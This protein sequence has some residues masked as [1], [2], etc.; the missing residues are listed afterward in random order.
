M[1]VIMCGNDYQQRRDDKVNPYGVSQ[2]FHKQ[3]SYFSIF[4]S[5]GVY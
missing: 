1:Y 5:P 2:D 3:C 4:T